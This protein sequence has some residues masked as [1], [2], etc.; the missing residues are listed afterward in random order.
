MARKKKIHSY[1]VAPM[2]ILYSSIDEQRMMI[3]RLQHFVDSI[4]V[5]IIINM[6][7]EF[8]EIMFSK[9]PIKCSNDRVVITCKQD[10]SMQLR[11]NGFEFEKVADMDFN[12]AASTPSYITL[13]GGQLARCHSLFSV[14]NMLVSGWI[15]EMFQ[16]CDFVRIFIKPISPT[17]YPVLLRG[18]AKTAQLSLKN[19]MI[20]GRGMVEEMRARVLTQSLSKIVEVRVICGVVGAT[21]K[22]LLEREKTFLTR[23]KGV[24]ATFRRIPNSDRPWLMHGRTDI[25]VETG[26]LHPLFPFISSELMENGGIAWG[27]NVVTNRA[28]VYNYRRRRNYNIS[29]VATSGAGKSHTIKIIVSRSHKKFPNAFFFFV[30]IENEYVEFAKKLGFSVSEVDTTTQLGM[31]PFNY[32]SPDKSASLLAEVLGVSKLTK[33]AMLEAAE[34]DCHSVNKLIENVAKLDE[35]NKTSYAPELKILKLGS[36][37]RLLSGKSTMAGSTVIALA[38]SFAVNSD[39]HRLATRI[40]LEFAMHHAISTVPRD[41]PKIIVLDE[42]WALFKDENTAES[43]EELARRARK[44]NVTI[45]LATQNIDDIIKHEHA[46]TLF[47]NSDTK[48]FLQHKST[49]KNALQQQLHISDIEAEILIRASKGEAMV[50][51][52]ENTVRV[53]F[54]ADDKE[55]EMFNTNP[56]LT[57][58]EAAEN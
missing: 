23:A 4:D 13:N 58:E 39:E 43:V 5:P 29:I 24:R 48:I 52:S 3:E 12:I 32:L 47:N 2:N 54:I 19:D 49:E 35:V 45:I 16:F 55:L 6:Y 1:L 22:E 51:A 18:S 9:K 25:R 40:S 41:T 10:I 15:Y 14:P 8:S 21:K 57:A 56:N 53:Q 36:I 27:V 34:T 28:V 17:K 38:H 7:R 30:D 11:M 50:H 20:D 42:G 33:Y 46:L 44:Y 37:K 26:S 31:D